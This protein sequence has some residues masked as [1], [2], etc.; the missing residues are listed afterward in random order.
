[1]LTNNATDTAWFQTLAYVATAMCFPA[2]RIRFW[3]PSR[4]TAT[5]LQGQTITGV[6]VEIEAFYRAFA[7]FGTVV[8]IERGA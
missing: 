7:P 5:P 8:R 1:M 2:G 6:G 4:E 3:Q